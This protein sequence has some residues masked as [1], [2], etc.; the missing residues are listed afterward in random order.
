M[1]PLVSSSEGEV[2]RTVPSDAL[3]SAVVI[4]R[5]EPLTLPWYIQVSAA[6]VSVECEVRWSLMG[7]WPRVHARVWIGSAQL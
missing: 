4:R 3:Y 1:P 7:M 2:Q 6:R 5:G